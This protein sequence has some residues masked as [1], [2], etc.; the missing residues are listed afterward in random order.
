MDEDSEHDDNTK[1][2][3]MNS[4]Y[5]PAH[6]H[7][8]DV[9]RV[10]PVVKPVKMNILEFLGTC[11]DSWIYTIEMYFDA[12]RTPLDQCM[13]MAVTYL[14]G[15]A[16]QWWRGTSYSA[17]MPCHRFCRHVGDRFAVTSY[18]TM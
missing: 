17:K 8:L 14:T 13:Q 1:G 15:D 3:M 2:N 7:Q 4:R 6:Q 10:F 16:M 12:D 9:R 5:I 11:V 18:V